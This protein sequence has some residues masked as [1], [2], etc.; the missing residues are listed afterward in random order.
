M[1]RPHLPLA[2][3]LPSDLVRGSTPAGRRVGVQAPSSP[4]AAPTPPPPTPP[5]KGEGSALRFSR[6]DFR[7]R[8]SSPTPSPPPC[9]EVDVRSTAGGG[10]GAIVSERGADTPT[11]NPSPQGGGERVALLSPG[12]ARTR[13]ELDS[14][15]LPL[16]GRSAPQVPGGGVGAIVSERGADTPTLAVPQREESEESHITPLRTCGPALPLPEQGGRDQRAVTPASGRCGAP[17]PWF[18]PAPGRRGRPRPR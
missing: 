8:R 3:C 10:A 4:N 1:A 14:L 18:R 15:D 6:L 13:F 7:E 5:H 2:G 17:G 9:G 12:L 11:P 16:V